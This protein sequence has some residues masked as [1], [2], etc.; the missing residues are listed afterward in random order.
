MPT[1]PKKLID[2]EEAAF[3]PFQ[4][5]WGPD[6]AL[7]FII[8]QGDAAVQRAVVSEFIRYNVS[9]SQAAAQFWTGLQKATEGKVSSF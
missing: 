7:K 8:E 1:P 3:F 2:K 6:P 4:P 5:W 9:T